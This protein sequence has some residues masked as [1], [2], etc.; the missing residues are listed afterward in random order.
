M[1]AGHPDVFVPLRET[2]TF[3]D[4]EGASEQWTRLVSEAASSGRTHLVEKT[5]RH[6]L[7]LALIRRT[8]PDA[9]FVI[10]VRDGRDVAASYVKRAG[11]AKAGAR[12]WLKHNSVVLAERGAADV[13][14][15]RYEDLVDSPGA[16]LEATCAFARVPF[17]EGMLAY[18]ETPRLWFGVTEVAPGTGANGLEHRMLRNWQINQPIFDDRGKWRRMLCPDDLAPFAT[19]RAREM[20]SAFGYD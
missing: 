4:E 18:H 12:R 11:S 1:F 13:H 2:G 17:D 19:P 16:A 20:L 9:R 15:L 6:L 3:L 7:R 14:I 5:P 8:V 10:L